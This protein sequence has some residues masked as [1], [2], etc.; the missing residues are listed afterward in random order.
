MRLEIWFISLLSRGCR[1][2][3]SILFF[4][5][6]TEVLSHA[7]PP[8][9]KNKLYTVGKWHRFPSL[10]WVPPKT[11]FIPIL[12]R[13]KPVP[14]PRSHSLEQSK[15]GNL[16]TSSEEDGSDISTNP[17]TTAK[18]ENLIAGKKRNFCCAPFFSLPHFTSKSIMKR[19]A[20]EFS[21]LQSRL[22]TSYENII[23][24]RA[25]H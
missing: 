1:L 20:H 17:S 10:L 4:L 6:S 15:M 23:R 2:N 13:A 12:G 16:S 14:P 3:I 8:T 18:N 21:P 11:S 19:S 22:A 5:Q 7:M 24:L 9:F 25:S